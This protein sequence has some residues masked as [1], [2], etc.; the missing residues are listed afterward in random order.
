MN[1]TTCITDGAYPNSSGSIKIFT[2]KRSLNQRQAVLPRLI[3]LSHQ[4]RCCMKLNINDPNTSHLP[5]RN[6][7]M[8]TGF[9]FH[10]YEALDWSA[11][12]SDCQRRLL[13]VCLPCK[14]VRKLRLRSRNAHLDPNRLN[15]ASIDY[16]TNAPECNISLPN[17]ANAKKKLPLC[18]SIARVFLLQ[19]VPPCTLSGRCSFISL[20]PPLCLPK[21][22]F[23]LL[24][25]IISANAFSWKKKKKTPP[26]L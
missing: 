1:D 20:R 25:S 5:V 9:G 4:E 15:Q 13:A 2:S 22:I 3:V 10:C 11:I 8:L 12:V 24:L 14:E 23:L 6:S 18:F 7:Q 21:C 17:N 26:F 16:G 19:A